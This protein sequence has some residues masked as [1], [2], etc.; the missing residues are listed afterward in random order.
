[1]EMLWAILLGMNIT[2]VVGFLA[3]NNYRWAIF[4]L[5]L[6]GVCAYKLS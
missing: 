1:M 4:S 5:F 2:L 6:V 3:L